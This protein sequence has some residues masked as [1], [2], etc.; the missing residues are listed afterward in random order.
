MSPPQFHWGGLQQ[1][2]KPPL[3]K[4][5]AAR[6]RRQHAS[7]QMIYLTAQRVSGDCADV[8]DVDYNRHRPLSVEYKAELA[9]GK[10]LI[11]HT[12]HHTHHT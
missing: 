2:A 4:P 1:G 8:R 7:N 5:P 10:R 6:H 11:K 3:V 12:Q 9:T